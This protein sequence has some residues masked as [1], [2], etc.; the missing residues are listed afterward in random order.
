MEQQRVKA[1]PFIRR[2]RD[3]VLPTQNR[4]GFVKRRVDDEIVSVVSEY[5]AARSSR[6]LACGLS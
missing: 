2:Q 5:A 3:D 6:R 4:V 1:L